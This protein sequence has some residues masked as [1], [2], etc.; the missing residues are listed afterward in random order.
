MN[1]VRPFRDMS[2]Y[3]DIKKFAIHDGPGIRTTV[4]LKGCPLN[5]VWCHNPESISP[6]KQLSFQERKCTFCGN[7]VT[8]CPNGCHTIT[9]PPDGDSRPEHRIDYEKCV[10]GGACVEV[11]LGRALSI[12]GME[13]HPDEILEEVLK[14]KAYY[15]ASGGGLTVSGG[16][17]A[18]HPDFLC[19]FLKKAKDAGLHVCLDTSGFASRRN[20]ERILPYVDIVL[21]DCKETDPARH[22]EYTGVANRPILENLAWMDEQGAT[23]ILRCPIIP[24][25]NDREEHFRA[26]GALADKHSHITEVHVLPF[27]PM[28]INKA[29]DKRRAEAYGLHEIGLVKPEQWKRWITTIQSTTKTI[30]KKG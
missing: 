29:R 8:A 17:P 14:D 15:D 21:F 27:H 23:I 19:E 4:F 6:E 7:C 18:I 24:G 5:C 20:Y 26:I 11:C 13:V 3:F 22:R 9:L 25:L 30:V 2:L 1:S 16:E 28:G 12:V 10:A